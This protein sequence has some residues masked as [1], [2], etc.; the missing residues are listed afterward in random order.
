MKDR[1]SVA[2]MSVCMSRD[3]TVDKL[4]GQYI[5][6]STYIRFVERCPGNEASYDVLRTLRMHTL[7][8]QAMHEV[9][10]SAGINR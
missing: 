2:R 9:N 4:S 7:N 3:Q 10:A 6:L 5:Q 1:V 8:V